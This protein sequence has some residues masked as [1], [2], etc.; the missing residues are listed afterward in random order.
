VGGGGAS[1]T[2]LQQVL[3]QSM[4]ASKAQAAVQ[5][6]QNRGPFTSI[7]DFAQKAGLTSA[8]LTPV[9]DKLSF[10]TATTSTGLININTAPREVLLTLPGLQP[11]DADAIIG[12]RQRADT[13]SIMWL[14]D[15]MSMQKAAQIGQ[16]VT[17]RSF[18]YSADIVA[19]SG[20]GR[21]FKRVRVVVD[22]RTSPAKI[23]YRKDLTSYGWP[24]PES[25]RTSLRDG[26]GPGASLAGG[27]G[28]GGGLGGMGGMGLR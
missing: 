26:K 12:E 22:A 1:G 14:G 15:A 9:A 4:S 16:Y 3:S 10:G 11:N 23:L 6:A 18:I 2:Q 5:A 13:S 28:L 8:D 24:L 27:T 7:F 21:A 20:D 19:V 25:V 17:N